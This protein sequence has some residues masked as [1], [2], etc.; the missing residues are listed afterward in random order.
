MA[1]RHACCRTCGLSD[2]L[3]PIP[4]GANYESYN[5]GFVGATT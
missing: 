5:Q 1:P 2:G 4:K 3:F